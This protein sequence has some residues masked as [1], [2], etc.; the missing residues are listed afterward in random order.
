MERRV[1]VRSGR[2]CPRR[3]AGSRRRGAAR[4]RSRTQPEREV[5]SSLRYAERGGTERLALPGGYGV[6]ARVRSPRRGAERMA[7]CGALGN[8]WCGGMLGAAIPAVRWDEVR[9]GAVR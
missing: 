9:R 5:F 6:A 7:R 3:W 2:C 8:P 1:Q 4:K